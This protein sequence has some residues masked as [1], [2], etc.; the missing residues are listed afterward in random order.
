MSLQM[1]LFHSFK[2]VSNILLYIPNLLYPLLCWWTFRL[3][4]VLAVVNCAS[5][6]IVVHVS[7]WITFSRYMPRS[8][9]AESYDNSIFSF[10]RHLH[11]VLHS[12]CTNLHSHQQ[13]RRVPFSQHPLQDLLF[14]DF[15]TAAILTSVRWYLFV[16]SICISLLVML[17][18]TEELMLLNCGVGEDSWASLGLQGDPTSPS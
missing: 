3:L 18:S 10:L 5:M 7:F 13:Y 12:G 6:N 16:I 8:G 17:L 1:A 11:A 2:W 4:P 15:F 14:V 9:I